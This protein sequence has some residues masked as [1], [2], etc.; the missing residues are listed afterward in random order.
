M[1]IIAASDVARAGLE[2]LIA[3]EPDFTIVGSGADLSD[4]ESQGVEGASPD[5]VIV[6]AERLGEE[7]LAA[8]RALVEGMYE[9]RDA[10]GL[11]VIGAER[12]EWL[13]EALRA[14]VVRGTLRRAASSG[15]IIA[16]VLAVSSGLIAVDAETFSAFLSPAGSTLDELPDA[17]SYDERLTTAGQEVDALTPRERE[18]L[19]MLAEGLS[20][21]EIASRM[22]ISEHTVKF[23]TAQIFA[24]LGVSTRTEAVVQGIRRGLIMM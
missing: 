12:G 14:G 10:P 9:G 4:L 1:F 18:V 6:D 13:S 3:R 15:E 2:S 21:K 11:V 22:K 8:M 20:N 7:T 5:I 23:H 16:A 19:E 17:E 24:K